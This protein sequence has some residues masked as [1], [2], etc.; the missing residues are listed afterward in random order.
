MVLVLSNTSEREVRYMFMNRIESVLLIEKK[1]E[2]G[3]SD[4]I[5]GSK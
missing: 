4:H 2:V 3:H 5:I 1:L